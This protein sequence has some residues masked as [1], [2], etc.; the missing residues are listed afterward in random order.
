MRP[1]TAD[2]VLDMLAT[3]ETL[4]KKG[5]PRKPPYGKRPDALTFE[6]DTIYRYTKRTNF[7]DVEKVS[8]AAAFRIAQQ[9]G[10]YTAYQR[11]LAEIEFRYGYARDGYNHT[12]QSIDG[13]ELDTR[14]LIRAAAKARSY[15]E[16]VW[17]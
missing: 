1:A 14:L 13:G 9:L 17:K 12:I 15:V 7:L 2:A 4:L 8:L 16:R 5:R 10:E 3:V 6:G 11:Q